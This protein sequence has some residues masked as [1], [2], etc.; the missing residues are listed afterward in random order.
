VALAAVLACSHVDARQPRSTSAKAEF[1][2]QH[3]CPATGR[4]RGACPGYVIDH[5]V[6]LACGGADRPQNMQWQTAADARR[7]DRWERIGC[8]WR[9]SP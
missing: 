6:A 5:R 8:D 9:S 2:A 7:K 4:T 1:H 3:P